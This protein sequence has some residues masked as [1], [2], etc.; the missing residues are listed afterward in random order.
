[1]L[2]KEK[3]VE[4]LGSYS[5]EIDNMLSRFT[6]SRN[7]LHIN[8]NDGNRFR[9]IV[10]E[11]TDLLKDHVLDSKNSVLKIQCYY[12]EG[13]ANFTSSPSY[14]SLE[15]VKGVIDSLIVRIEQNPSLC[16]LPQPEAEEDTQSKIFIGHGRSSTWRDLKDFITDRLNLPVEEFNSVSAAGVTNINRLEQMLD[17]TSFAF[18]IMTGED[19]QLDGKLQ[20]RMNVIHEAGLFQGRH[21]FSRA[22]IVLEKGCEE[23]S[24]IEG[25]GQIR[26]AKGN[27]SGTFEEIRRVLEREGLL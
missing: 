14:A 11:V 20:P 25:L 24:N 13:I 16:A 6:R 26:F 23:F 5:Q 9:N 3:I 4:L 18:L 8:R 27:I 12:R 19:E 21:G 15:E 10:N 1:M 22:I 7:G 2:G 17:T